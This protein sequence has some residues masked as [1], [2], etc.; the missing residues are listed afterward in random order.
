MRAERAPMMVSSAL[1]ESGTVEVGRKLQNT[2]TNRRRG[3]C[4]EASHSRVETA[5]QRGRL[6]LDSH[7][8]SR[9]DSILESPASTI[10]LCGYLPSL[11]WAIAAGHCIPEQCM[12]EESLN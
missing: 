12:E 7:L 8:P 3:R 5:S 4:T 6:E 11:L 9:L 10:H 2:V 1:R